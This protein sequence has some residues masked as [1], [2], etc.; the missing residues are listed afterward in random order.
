MGFDGWGTRHQRSSQ[1]VRYVFTFLLYILWIYNE[2]TQEQEGP[3]NTFDS[4]P[5]ESTM[6]LRLDAS[7]KAEF[8]AAA[9][10]E[11][12]PA[13]EV[14]R[15]LMRNYIDDIRRRRFAAEAR[16]QSQLIAGSEDEAEVMRWIEDVSAAPKRRRA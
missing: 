13:A 11:Q 6:N 8:T 4:Q 10:A 5:K 16:R 12:R 15:I 1:D 3:V 2:D 14:I 9:E 7:L